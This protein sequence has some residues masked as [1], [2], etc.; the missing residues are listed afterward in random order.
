MNEPRMRAKPTIIKADT[1][2]K[3]E[4]ELHERK[5]INIETLRVALSS[6]PDRWIYECEFVMSW[7]HPRDE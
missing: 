6:I 5:R 1:R 7:L 4:E 3:R 2:S